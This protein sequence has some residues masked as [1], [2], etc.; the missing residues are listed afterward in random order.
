MVGKRCLTWDLGGREGFWPIRSSRRRRH[1]FSSH[2][3]FLKIHR[4][5]SARES[6][7]QAK[8]CENGVRI[9]EIWREAPGGGLK[10]G[11]NLGKNSFLLREA[12]AGGRGKNEFI[13]AGTFLALSPPLPT[14][15]LTR[16]TQPHL[17]KAPDPYFATSDISDIS[18]VLYYPHRFHPVVVLIDTGLQ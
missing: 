17:P 6:M 14:R 13:L 9:G 18:T 8:K 4:K 5:V 1:K 11:G 10:F 15:R 16:N 2:G 3:T 12:P 7:P